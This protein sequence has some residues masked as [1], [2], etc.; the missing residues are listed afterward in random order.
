MTNWM[1][2]KIPDLPHG[3]IEKINDKEKNPPE[4]NPNRPTIEVPVPPKPDT[5]EPSDSNKEERRG[6]WTTDI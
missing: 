5:T 2:E 4:Q 6:V 3:E 1:P